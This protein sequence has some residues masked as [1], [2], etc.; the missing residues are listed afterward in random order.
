MA[1][2]K[3]AEVRAAK[4]SE[5]YWRANIRLQMQL[6][7]VWA[8]VGYLLAILLAEPLNN[9][10]LGSFPLGFWIAQQGSI[11]TFVVLIFIYARRMDTIDE[12]HDVHEQRLGI[13]KLAAERRMQETLTGETPFAEDEGGDR[14]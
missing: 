6:L 3:N 4:R 10:K 7:L 1:Q 14:T 9:I 13:A 12:E 8:I 11:I 5:H 2:G